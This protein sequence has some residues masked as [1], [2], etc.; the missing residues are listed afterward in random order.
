[1]NREQIQAFYPLSKSV[2]S[3]FHKMGAAAAAL[4]EG[5]GISTGMRAVLENVVEGGPMT[6][7]EMARMRPVSR[8]HIQV[9]VNDLLA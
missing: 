6:V 8:Q 9:L 1:M 4:H 5:S 7:P 3:L 2:R